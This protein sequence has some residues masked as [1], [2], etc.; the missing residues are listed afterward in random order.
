MSDE[1]EIA[2][3]LLTV[4]F[5]GRLT[6]HA[7]NLQLKFLNTFTPLKVP[8]QFDTLLNKIKPLKTTTEEYSKIWYCIV[9]SKKYDQLEYRTQTRCEKCKSR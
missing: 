2:A 9:C 3:A 1:E 8:C 5:N 4:F 6:Q 7:F